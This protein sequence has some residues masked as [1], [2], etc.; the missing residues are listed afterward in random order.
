VPSA[1]RDQADLD[2]HELPGHLIRRLQ[3]I[4]VAVFLQETESLGVTPV[5]FAAIQAVAATPGIDQR[6]LSGQ[7][8]LDTST[9][10][11]VIDRLE[12]RGLLTR[13]VSSAD[14]RAR[15]LMLTHE[16]IQTLGAVQPAMLRAQERILA[17]LPKSERR[18]F[19][20]MLKV[21]VESNNELS[22]APAEA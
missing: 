4:A 7:I 17:P 2:L 12:S 19:V 8:G 6:T 15:V 1:K 21:L 10:A 16:G 13:A 20:R 9:V 11:G 14:R 3:Q 5:Q 18:E 22:R